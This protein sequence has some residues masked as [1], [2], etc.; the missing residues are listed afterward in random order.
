MFLPELSLSYLLY[1]YS[2]TSWDPGVYQTITLILQLLALPLWGY[3]T[4]KIKKLSRRSANRDMKIEALI[5]AN[6][7]VNGDRAKEFSEIYSQRYNE[8]VQEYKF[9]DG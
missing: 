6:K 4:I 1:S 2:G 8:L 3:I 9:L 7:H 5:H